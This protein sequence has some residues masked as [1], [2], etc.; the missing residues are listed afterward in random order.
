MTSSSDT[1]QARDTLTQPTPSF[2]W[3]Y[4]MVNCLLVNIP[5]T[6]YLFRKWAPSTSS[7]SEDKD[8]I[9]AV[10]Y[11]TVLT[12]QLPVEHHLTGTEDEEGKTHKIQG[13]AAPHS[14]L[15]Q[16]WCVYPSGG[17]Q[18]WMSQVLLLLSRIC[19]PLVE[20]LWSLHNAPGPITFGCSA[21]TPSPRSSAVL[22][23]HI[24]SSPPCQ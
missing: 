7:E 21:H 23:Q 4:L 5:W 14:P 22:P 18:W 3:T 16:L 9:S 2:S 19:S 10:W 12:A 1:H 15:W 20:R 17:T 13:M 8:V 24:S 11:G 6:R